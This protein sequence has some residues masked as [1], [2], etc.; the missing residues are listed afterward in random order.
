MARTGH[1]AR[2]AQ[3]SNCRNHVLGTS[4]SL[5]QELVS[6]VGS[7]RTIKNGNR[8]IDCTFPGSKRESDFR[9]SSGL[10]IAPLN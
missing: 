2:A 8:S 3:Y 7:I 6:E 5:S 1:R 4:A 9:A 10:Y